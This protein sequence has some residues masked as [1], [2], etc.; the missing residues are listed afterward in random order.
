M[1]AH[2]ITAPPH[3]HTKVRAQT[4]L[5][6]GVACVL[7]SSGA[8]GLFYEH[9]YITS[10]DAVVSATLSEIRTPIDGFITDLSTT[11]GTKV[12]QG[13]LLGRVENTRVDHQQWNLL[14]T[15]AGYSEA[16]VNAATTEQISLVA[17]RAALLKLA[18]EHTAAIT[19]RLE[20]QMT[21]ASRELAA[22]KFAQQHATAELERG[23]SLYEAGILTTAAFDGLVA[24][25]RI[26]SEEVAAQEAQL[27]SLH[28]QMS[29]AAKG[30]LSEPGSAAGVLYSYQRAD[31]LAMRLLETRRTM[32]MAEE[33][34]RKAN[35]LMRLEKARLELLS[36]ES[37][38]SG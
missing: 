20:L 9:A 22:R 11:P 36:H 29:S 10:S 27:E 26:V 33:Q 18:R 1:A 14:N 34:A 15:E 21:S 4:L 5:K 37:S 35:E 2:T 17:Q 3:H 28:T 12:R 13:E 30:F 6:I 24:A 31:E 38:L 8:Y 19:S 7:V 23:R 25:K 32:A 16:A